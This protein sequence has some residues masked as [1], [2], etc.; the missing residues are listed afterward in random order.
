MKSPG[1]VCIALGLMEGKF[2]QELVTYEKS[3]VG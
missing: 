2:A 3:M 1:F